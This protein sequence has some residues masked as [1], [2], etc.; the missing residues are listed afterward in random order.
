[1]WMNALHF[2]CIVLL[3]SPVWRNQCHGILAFYPGRNLAFRESKHLARGHQASQR[4]NQERKASLLSSQVHALNQY[5][6]SI[7]IH[8]CCLMQ[9][10]QNTLRGQAGHEC[11]EQAGG[12]VTDWIIA[13]VR[14]KPHVI[15]PCGLQAQACSH[16]SNFFEN[17]K[18]FCP[19][20]LD[21]TDNYFNLQ[22]S[23]SPTKPVCRWGRPRGC[24]PASCAVKE[25]LSAGH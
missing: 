11:L 7:F 19:K 3:K 16:S 9:G 4:Q 22:Q 2:L 25:D 5:E 15:L 13:Q 14:L 17:K 10:S 21:L 24:Q 18:S 6:A 20:S 12:D 1:M 8:L 23:V